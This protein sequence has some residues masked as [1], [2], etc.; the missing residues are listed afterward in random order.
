MEGRSGTNIR[1]VEKQGKDSSNYS[2]NDNGRKGKTGR[3]WT[4]R[5]DGRKRMSGEA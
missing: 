5:R 1:I 3:R 4:K 2:S